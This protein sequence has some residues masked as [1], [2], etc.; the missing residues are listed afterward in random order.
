M[1]KNITTKGKN[2]WLL[3]VYITYHDI[4]MACIAFLLPGDSIGHQFMSNSPTDKL[5]AVRLQHFRA[6]LPVW[7]CY[8]GD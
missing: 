5:Y 7:E 4:T 6:D 1:K 8:H 2:G 3:Y